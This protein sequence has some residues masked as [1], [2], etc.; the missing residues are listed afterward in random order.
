MFDGVYDDAPPEHRPKYGALNLHTDP[1]GAAPRFGS[2]YL[3]LQEGVLD[4]AT[5]A[6]PDSARD[7]RLFGTADRMGLLSTFISDRSADPIDH[8]VEAHVHGNIDVPGDVEA[9]VLDP[10]FHDT[11]IESEAANLGCAIEWHPGYRARIDDL[12]AFP[13]FRGVHVLEAAAEIAVGGILTPRELTAA[14]R[15]QQF[16]LQT[17]KF[18]WHYLARYGR[19]R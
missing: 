9:I 13:E 7:P 10:S 11:D 15:S 18:V 16:D 14:R 8:Y 19:R 5:F 17:I 2:A 6:Y 1:Y 3:R 4:R 12:T